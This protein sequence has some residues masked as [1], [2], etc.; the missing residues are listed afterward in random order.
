[1]YGMRRTNPARKALPGEVT[2][3]PGPAG[4]NGL[5]TVS[6]FKLAGRPYT[7]D[8]STSRGGFVRGTSELA[9]GSALSRQ[10]NSLLATVPSP[11]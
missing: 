10:A 4:R 11:S 9:A 6:G 7:I 1:L 3:L 2:V 5:V 8:S